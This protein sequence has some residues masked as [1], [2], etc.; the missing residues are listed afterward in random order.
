VEL[1]LPVLVAQLAD[2]ESLD[3]L[4]AVSFSN[5]VAVVPLADAPIDA[6]R[7]VLE[8][9]VPGAEQPVLFFAEPAGAPRADGFPLRLSGY[10]P[11]DVAVE[12]TSPAGALAPIEDDLGGPGSATAGSPVSENALYGRRRASTPRMIRSPTGD[13]RGG[14]A[15]RPE[16]PE[17]LASEPPTVRGKVPTA[18]SL[19][20]L[21][22]AALAGEDA[23]PPSTRSNDDLL[24][25][26]IAGGKY[27]VLELLGKGG[28]GKVYRAKH[29]DLH[30]PVA[31]K[32]LHASFQKDLDFC[33]RF[34][35]EALAASKL[36]HPNIVR[37]LDFGQEEDGMLY[38]VMEFL[39]GRTLGALIDQDWPLKTERIAE[40]MMQVCVGLQL[41]HENGIIHRDIKPDNI[42]MVPDKDPDGN[43]V[44]IAKVCDFGIAQ[45]HV[46]E[47]SGELGGLLM[48]EM[49]RGVAGTP[50]YMSPEQCRGD[51]LDERSDV[52]ACGIVLYEL[53]T[54]RV[55]FSDANP[56][57]LLR[58]HFEDT[59]VPPSRLVPSVDPLL[60]AIIL[61]AL[62]KDPAERQQSMREMRTELKELLEPIMVESPAEP[63]V[64]LPER[65]EVFDVAA[66]A[67]LDDPSAGFQEM[68]VAFSGAISRTGY[69]ERGHPEADA[70]LARL[71]KTMEVPLRHRGEISIA[72]AEVGGRVELSVLSG[73]GEVY[74]LKKLL[75]LSVVAMYEPKLGEVFS[76]RS[77]IALTIMD[78][79]TPAELGHV[80]ELLSGPEI[81]VAQLRA[82]AD[83]L[84]LH[85]AKL[86]FA[87]DLLGRERRL[88]WQVD[89]CISRL[90]RDLRTLPLLRGVDNERMRLLRVQLIADVV[91]TLSKPEH[92]FSLLDNVDLVTREVERLPE[93]QGLD[94][95]A[96]F[97]D[98]VPRARCLAAARL[99]LEQ[100]LDAKGQQI[101]ATMSAK[102]ARDRSGD[103]DVLLQELYKRGVLA[104]AQL[105]P[106]IAA[107][108]HAEQRLEIL[109][110]DP[111]GYLAKVLS[112]EDLPRFAAEMA[113][114]E[115][116]MSSLARRGEA[117]ALQATV[118]ALGAFANK[119]PPGDD[120]REG[121]AARVRRSVFTPALLL[122]IAEQYL[123][124]PVERRE[125]AKALAV[126]G[127]EAGAHALYTAR[128]RLG[129][130]GA[131]P[132][133][134]AAMREIGAPCWPVLSAALQKL[135]P[136]QDPSFDPALA[137]DLLRCVPNVVDEVA[138]SLV[139]KLVRQGP[140]AVAKAAVGALVTLWGPRAKPLL[141]GTLDQGDDGVRMAALAA[142]RKMRSVDEHVLARIDRILARSVPGGDDLRAAA[143]GA[144][145][146]VAQPL[147]PQA[148]ELLKR[149]AQ[150]KAKVMALLAGK[151]A[152]SAQV[153]VACA[154]VLLAIGGEQGR[155]L[156]EDRAERSDGSLRDQLYEL[157]GA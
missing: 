110:R 95:L 105:P 113:T 124:G 57:N 17:H 55:P 131:R 93:Y 151:Q 10:E 11:P 152:E 146:D 87:D 116:V 138:G 147:R 26:T 90:A 119:T 123:A 69:Y 99:V 60:E 136:I 130:P 157:L 28:I 18:T 5:G 132:R 9:W 145:A 117:N 27:Q 64:Q 31:I 102:F 52:Y 137:E 92:V 8:A 103:S 71:A 115:R 144:L 118:Q 122:P 80:I 126:R 120:T 79:I 109:M 48:R 125:S 4:E 143:A 111:Q 128:E 16:T 114:L 33:S 3:V 44:E 50:E 154:R 39:A 78:G 65:R 112:I 45:H 149:T 101:L 148:I 107:W 98:A 47:V 30:K 89:L 42:I 86:L 23:L 97:V 35:G 76:R 15:P 84:R 108:V 58:K 29:R 56:L 62:R 68:F 82:Q 51:E 14:G 155:A 72:R 25:K 53:A 70:A 63:P 66:L 83:R 46:P 19:S 6:S 43:P 40:I 142:L 96:A 2:E 139:S 135:P 81:S 24:G 75:P 129:D 67:K 49:D 41:A 61:K 13:R 74:E 37:V 36:D 156:V 121:L 106:D 12:S 100:P 94:L 54:R 32:V 34:Y 141:V 150:A 1:L 38:I 20:E 21:H 134:V 104:R 7:H 85:Y 59:P 133:F 153:V 88:A 91:R 73:V 127:R 140:P 77:V 22:A